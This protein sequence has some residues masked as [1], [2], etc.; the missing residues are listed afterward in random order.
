MFLFIFFSGTAHSNPGAQ[1]SQVRWQRFPPQSNPVYT[2]RVDFSDLVFYLSSHQ[3]SQVLSLPLVFLIPNKPTTSPKLQS[4]V[5]HPTDT[6]IKVFYFAFT[7]TFHNTEPLKDPYITLTITNYTNFVYYESINR[8]LKRRPLG[9]PKD[10][11]EVNRQEVWEY[12]GWVCVLEVIGVPSSL[13]FI[14]KV[15][16]LKKKRSVSRWS[17]KN[18]RLTNSLCNLP[19]VLVIPGI[20]EITLGDCYYSKDYISVFCQRQSFRNPT[21]STTVHSKILVPFP[22]STQC[23]WGF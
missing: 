5:F 21:S 11:N 4:L 16:S 2:R 10:R 20:K 13:R 12:D 8:K 6:H 3:H 19:D 15:S 18:K 22:H 17:C 7:L 9:T 1:G 23:V 14:R